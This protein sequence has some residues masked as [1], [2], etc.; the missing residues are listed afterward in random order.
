[1]GQ[2]TLLPI[3]S[4]FQQPD[5]ARDNDRIIAI[6]ALRGFAL[7]GM[8]V[9]H[10]VEQYMGSPPPASQPSFGVFSTVDM[11]ARG[12]VG[13]LFMGKFFAMFSLLFGLSFFIQMDRTSG[14][15]HAFT[16]R[17]LW[18]LALL[19]VIGAAHHLFY[20]GDILTIYAMLGASLVLFYRASAR[21]ILVVA[22]LLGLGVPRLLLVGVAEAVGVRWMMLPDD[23]AVQTYFDTLRGG[24]LLAV[25]VSNVR[26]GFLTK[27]EFQFGVFGRGYQT[28]ALFLIGLYLGR[29]R[30]HESLADLRRPLRRI[31]LWGGVT[32]LAVGGVFGLLVATGGGPPSTPAA[33]TPWQA[34]VGLGLYDLFNLGFMCFLMAGFLLLYRAP[35]WHR[36]LRS[37]APVGQ[38]ALTSYVCQSLIGTFIFYGY[39]LGR[40]GQIGAAGAVLLALLVFAA[41]VGVA[42]LWLRSFRFGPVEWLW[43]SLTYGQLQ[44]FQVGRHGSALPA[45]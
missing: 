27:L 8:V 40:L 3:P 20:R 11:V 19:F 6:D 12:I 22:V 10:M 26:E 4:E 36:V 38:T 41:Q 7:F 35:A 45:A 14:R 5:R 2:Q 30:W 23:R 24:S 44:P 15:G 25:F 9:V 17:F 37:L 1:M 39:G 33:I 16:G 32:F 31:A 18:R 42:A 28:L 34:V 29:L 13:L 43:R 21:T